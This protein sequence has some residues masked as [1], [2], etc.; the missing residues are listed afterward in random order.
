VKTVTKIEE[1][2]KGK[3]HTNTRKLILNISTIRDI[4]LNQKR[5]NVWR[6]EKVFERCHHGVVREKGGE[7]M[8]GKLNGNYLRLIPGLYLEDVQVQD[9]SR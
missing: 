8:E 4:F 5:A 7:G 9:G 3:A 2:S 6:H 1:I